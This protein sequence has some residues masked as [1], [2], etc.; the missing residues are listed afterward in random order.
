M[1][2]RCAWRLVKVALKVGRKVVLKDGRTMGG[3]VHLAFLGV[4]VAGSDCD[5]LWLGK[6]SAS[7]RC[8][9]RRIALGESCPQR[10][11]GHWPSPLSAQR[12][13]LRLWSRRCSTLTLASNRTRQRWLARV[14]RA[15]TARARH[16]DTCGACFCALLRRCQ[17]RQVPLWRGSRGR[18]A[19][20]LFSAKCFSRRDLPGLPP[21]DSSHSTWEIH[22]VMSWRR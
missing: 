14:A 21:S 9:W 18:R 22:L 4:L 10:R 13:R 16:G 7:L 8:A 20:L 15:S 5:C 11:G 19:D 2:A 6:R 17:H 3:S 1:S 12:R